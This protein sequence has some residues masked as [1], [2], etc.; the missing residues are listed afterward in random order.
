MELHFRRCGVLDIVKG[1]EDMPEENEAMKKF[2]EKVAGAHYDLLLCLGGKL[3]D[4]ALTFTSL[5]DAWN[6]IVD[7]CSMADDVELQKAEEELESF[8]FDG[9]VL[10]TIAGLK[11]VFERLKSAGGTI[12][13][14][15]KVLKL[16]KIL[17]K[18]YEELI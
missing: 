10:T 14:S 5:T 18:S 16:L 11:S 15:Q 12:S 6:A 13:D 3:K 4:Y 17:P 1:N 7:L 9:S 8:S 2:D